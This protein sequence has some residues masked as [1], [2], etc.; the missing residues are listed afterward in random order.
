MDEAMPGMSVKRS[1][2]QR[3]LGTEV[4]K[5]RESERDEQGKGM[6]Q[7]EGSKGMGMELEG[8]TGEGK[9]GEGKKGQMAR[10]ED[11]A[12]RSWRGLRWCLCM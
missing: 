9:K 2:S 8:E 6:E 7:V 3:S 11:E 10:E 12:G 5:R 1:K 4:V